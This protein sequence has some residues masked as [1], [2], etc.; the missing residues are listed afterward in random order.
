VRTARIQVIKAAVDAADLGAIFALARLG[1]TPDDVAIRARARAYSL[2]EDDAV[3]TPSREV[4]EALLLTA[5]AVGDEAAVQAAEELI[6]E[7]DGK[8]EPTTGVQ[9]G[10][11]TVSDSEGHITFWVHRKSLEANFAPGEWIIERLIGQQ[12]DDS[13]CYR[14]VGFVNR[15]QGGRGTVVLFKKQRNDV[16]LAEAVRILEGDP[17]MAGR[18]YAQAASSCWRCNRDLTTPASI[19][20]GIGPICAEK[21]GF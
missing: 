2:K 18:G 15:R 20:A 21:I 14:A 3:Q 10:R 12:N 9:K 19:D 6:D 11:Y 17:L 8:P 1:D 7:L 4:R 13:S 5:K 16:R